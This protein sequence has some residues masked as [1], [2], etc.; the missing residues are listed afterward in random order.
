[1]NTATVNVKG[2]I[3]IPAELRK[4]Y[5]LTTGKKVIFL[6]KGNEI[7]ITGS[8]KEYVEQ[9]AGILPSDSKVLE[10]LLKERQKDKLK[11]K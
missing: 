2:Q 9:F 10:S 8:I 11:D 1:M 5:G 7:I 3:V 4:K 6:E